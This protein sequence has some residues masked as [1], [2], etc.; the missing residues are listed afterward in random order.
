MAYKGESLWYWMILPFGGV[1]KHKTPL[2]SDMYTHAFT[3][4]RAF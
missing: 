1:L 3:Y 2:Q 4:T